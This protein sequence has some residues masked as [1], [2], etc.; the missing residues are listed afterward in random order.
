MANVLEKH[1]LKRTKNREVILDIIKEANLPI[2]AEEIY[3]IAT[4][5]NLEINLSTVYRTLKTLENKGVLLKQLRPDGVSYFQEN[6]HDH[7]H[8]FICSRC[9]KSILLDACPL[10]ELVH[11]LEKSEGF[12]ITAH[13]IE[14]Y[15]LC[16]KCKILAK[17]MI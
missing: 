10:E 1:N 4:L 9:E 3:K 13:N 15:G 16:K 7:K 5:K 2:S 8:L 6:K 11:S 14:L 17:K 12:E